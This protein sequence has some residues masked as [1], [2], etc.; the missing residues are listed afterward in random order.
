MDKPWIMVKGTVLL[1]NWKAVPFFQL[2]YFT[3]L[4]LG[5][6]MMD[7]GREAFM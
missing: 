7:D 3:D 6:Q 2:Y 5:Y 4:Q 1:L